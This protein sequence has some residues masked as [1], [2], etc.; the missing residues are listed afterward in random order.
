MCSVKY[1]VDFDDARQVVWT[2]VCQC[3]YWLSKISPPKGIF[4]ENQKEFSLQKVS[5]P[6]FV[7]S[8]LYIIATVPQRVPILG[9][10]SL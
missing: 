2:E 7:A 1:S 9:T 6:L 10:G 8:H 3:H 5:L 4:N